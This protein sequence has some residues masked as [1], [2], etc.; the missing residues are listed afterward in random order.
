MRSFSFQKN[1]LFTFLFFPFLLIACSTHPVNSGE[2]DNGG[3][4]HTPKSLGIVTFTSENQSYSANITSF[5]YHSVLKTH[6]IEYRFESGHDGF[7][8]FLS[9]N[10][11][12]EKST[13]WTTF[14]ER[15]DGIIFSK[16][17]GFD[18][19]YEVR[20]YGVA[21]SG[22][23]IISYLQSD[24]IKGRFSG[25]LKARNPIS[26]FPEQIEMVD[27]KFSLYNKMDTLNLVFTYF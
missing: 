10:E 11:L 3:N 2:S 8:G 15:N 25:K 21:D 9:C 4:H 19:D 5:F 16:L 24:S 18:P 27:G 13:N 12:L 22:T 26:G 17:T 6:V 20:Y 23:T 1:T 14:G 7:Y